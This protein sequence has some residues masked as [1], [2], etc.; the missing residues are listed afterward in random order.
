MDTLLNPFPNTLRQLRDLRATVFYS[1]MDSRKRSP[2]PLLNPTNTPEFRPSRSKSRSDELDVPNALCDK[3]ADEKW[4]PCL[5][6][7]NDLKVMSATRI[8]ITPFQRFWY[9]HVYV[10]KDIFP[11]MKREAP[12]LKQVSA[13]EQQKFARDIQTHLKDNNLFI[14]SFGNE[15]LRSGFWRCLLH[16]ATISSGHDDKFIHATKLNCD[17]LEDLTL[18]ALD[19][20]SMAEA[21]HAIALLRTLLVQCGG[22]ELSRQS[23]FPRSRQTSAHVLSKLFGTFKAQGPWVY[24]T[25]GKLVTRITQEGQRPIATGYRPAF[26][27]PDY[28]SSAPDDVLFS[29]KYKEWMEN[30]GFTS[31]LNLRLPDLV[32]LHITEAQAETIKEK[33]N[34][35]C[36][37]IQVP[38][39]F[40][41]IL[42]L[43]WYVANGPS[44]VD[45]QRHL[46]RASSRFKSYLRRELSRS[47][48]DLMS[49]YFQSLLSIFCAVESLP[50]DGTLT[51]SDA[52]LTYFV[53]LLQG[54]TPSSWRSLQSV[55]DAFDR[56]RKQI[57]E[58]PEKE[59]D[60]RV[61]YWM[62]RLQ[63]H[64][65]ESAYGNC[66]LK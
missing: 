56:A 59:D 33:T 52:D 34:A 19:K 57:G 43:L 5:I 39:Q 48:Q 10:L 15:S 18:R 60:V 54:R 63:S 9:W 66:T 21:L 1:T 55:L 32:G 53:D 38:S 29:L 16:Y 44:D 30:G 12:L 45:F 13:D 20:M 50:L 64:D 3:G 46:H 2:S 62:F 61:R 11:T 27:K 40:H 25:G 23:S 47:D 51:H 24:E 58:R 41:D 26:D 17:D 4:L 65:H 42:G 6:S 37:D 7:C 8:Y 14:D 22:Q 35:L 36:G 49:D 31:P 28:W